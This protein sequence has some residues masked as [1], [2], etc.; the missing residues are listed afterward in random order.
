ML[1]NALQVAALQ[2]DIMGW[3]L[4]P[5]TPRYLD[6]A[7]AARNIE[8]IQR[9]F[10][11]VKHWAVVLH[12]NTA[13]LRALGQ[14]D[15]FFQAIQIVWP[16]SDDLPGNTRPLHI[17][18]D[19]S[20]SLGDL[21]FTASMEPVPA[22][23]VKAQIDNNSLQRILKCGHFVLDA[24]VAGQA[25]GTGHRIR[26]EWIQSVQRPFLLAGGL[27]PLNVTQAIKAA[28]ASIIGADS[29]SGLENGIAGV[30]DLAKVKAWIKAIHNYQV[31]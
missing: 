3:V 17:A 27:D 19:G 8:R 10:P 6:P 18:A 12:S 4:V 29:S 14:F 2:P 30:K 21:Q 7:T 20:W 9:S 28:P 22:I 5:G 26:S 16:D 24:W 15:Q 25:G 13:Q 31:L 1:E 11:M 23:R